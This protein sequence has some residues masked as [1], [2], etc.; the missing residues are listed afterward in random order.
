[1]GGFPVRSS[2]TLVGWCGA[3]A[4]SFGKGVPPSH[5]EQKRGGE[6]GVL[7]TSRATDLSL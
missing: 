3:R 7:A 6:G 2:W 4:V 5:Q 1:M